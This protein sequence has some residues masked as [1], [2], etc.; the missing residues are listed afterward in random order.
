[1]KRGGQRVALLHI[2]PEL[3][4]HTLDVRCG[5]SGPAV[6]VYEVDVSRH[7]IRETLAQETESQGGVRDAVECLGY[8][9]HG[10]HYSES[11]FMQDKA[12][13]SRLMLALQPSCAVNSACL[14]ANRMSRRSLPSMTPVNR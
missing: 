1:M 9:H 7:S 5:N 3:D 8:V 13:S 2:P 11:A 4:P 6:V 10:H 12:S 14:L